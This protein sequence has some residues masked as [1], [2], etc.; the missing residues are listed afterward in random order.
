MSDRAAWRGLPMG[1]SGRRHEE[2]SQRA[3]S[4]AEVR[5]FCTVAIALRSHCDRASCT[6]IRTA[7][8]DHQ[9]LD[10]GSTAPAESWRF[11][12][13]LTSIVMD[14]STEHT[15]A[16]A[17]A[18]M[19]RSLASMSAHSRGPASGATL[20]RASV[21]PGTKFLVDR[22]ALGRSTS[23]LT[24]SERRWYRLKV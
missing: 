3:M 14:E 11:A 17:C 15:D 1:L 13:E 2:E 16:S 18:G 22:F 9:S 6:A 5:T 8:Q 4:P 20:K 21:A 23:C 24:M 7:R 19:R 10:A 12:V